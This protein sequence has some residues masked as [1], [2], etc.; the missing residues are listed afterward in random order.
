MK[1]LP[2]FFCNFRQRCIHRQCSKM[3]QRVRDRKLMPTDVVTGV[4]SDFSAPISASVPSLYDVDVSFAIEEHNFQDSTTGVIDSSFMKNP[5]TNDLC[6]Q[7]V[8]ANTFLGTAESQEVYPIGLKVDDC[9]G[10]ASVNDGRI[11]AVSHNNDVYIQDTDI[12]RVSTAA[13]GDNDLSSSSNSSYSSIQGD[14]VVAAKT[15][16]SPDSDVE[17]EAEFTQSESLP[18]GV[19]QRKVKNL[20]NC[21]ICGKGFS[22][23]VYALTHCQPK[24]TWRCS[25]CFVEIM[26]VTRKFSRGGPPFPGGAKPLRG[27]HLLG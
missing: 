20:F 9:S 13:L 17:S 21:N 3:N 12:R 14:E 18:T 24:E 15:I 5:D 26:G 2:P 27:H 19:N 8:N 10:I 7:T 4:T 11:H 1:F 22:R 25:K 23:K 6:N 16:T